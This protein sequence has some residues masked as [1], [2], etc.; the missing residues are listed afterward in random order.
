MEG[1]LQWGCNRAAKPDKQFAMCAHDI[2][3]RLYGLSS[4]SRHAT[5]RTPIAFP[6]RRTR[7]CARGFQ[8]YTRSHLQ[9]CD[10]PGGLRAVRCSLLGSFCCF[11]CKC[12]V[13]PLQLGSG[14]SRAGL[15]FRCFAHVLY[16]CKAC[17]RRHSA[18]FFS[19][20]LTVAVALSILGLT[21][22]DH[23][24]HV[25]LEEGYIVVGSVRN[26]ARV[27]APRHRV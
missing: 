14:N 8:S 13:W 24:A 18:M 26:V 15:A 9:H 7:G 23:V 2:G 12:L 16:L 19:P 25:H 20:S 6:R 22:A 1:K 21:V 5:N 17:G 11:F 10:F 4:L 27:C 3:L